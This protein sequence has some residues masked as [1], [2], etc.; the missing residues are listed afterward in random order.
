MYV[1]EKVGKVVS[2]CDLVA[3]L[4]KEVSRSSGE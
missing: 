3:P 2:Y 1:L 4:A